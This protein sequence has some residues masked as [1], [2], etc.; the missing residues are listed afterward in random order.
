MQLALAVSAFREIGGRLPRRGEH[1]D[2][3][4]R[5]VFRSRD[6]LVPLIL[7]RIDENTE[8]REAELIRAVA[9]CSLALRRGQ[10]ARP[11]RVVDTAEAADALIGG[12]GVN[13]TV[14]CDD[15]ERIVRQSRYTAAQ[16]DSRAGEE[17]SSPLECF[18]HF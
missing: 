5:G 15:A 14:G 17:R 7:V 10:I 18:F 13:D 1:R 16:Q 4:V 9:E 2:A 11:F 12:A 3:V 6:G 8:H